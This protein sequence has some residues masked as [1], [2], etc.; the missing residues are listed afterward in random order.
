MTTKLRD[1]DAVILRF[2][3]G[4]NSRASEDQINPLECTDGQNFILDPGNSEFRR[5]PPFDFVAAAPN[6]E[7]IRGFATLQDANGTVTMLVQAGDTVYSFNGVSS[8]TSVGSVSATARLRGPREAYWALTDEVIITDLALQED[9]L[10]WDGST[11]ST[12][13]FLQNDGSSSFGTL[14]AKYCL[15]DNERA[16]FANIVE[17]ANDF[18]HLL[19]ASAQGDY[20]IVSASDRPSSSLSAEDP[21]F[22]PAPQLRPINGLAQLYGVLVISQENGAFEKL[23]GSSAMDYAL[24]RLHPGSGATGD[25][26]VVSI[27][28]DIV[29][30][31]SGKIESLIATDRFGDVQV[32][33][34]SFK[35]E[36]SVRA[37]RIWRLY[38]NPRFHRVYCF[39]EQ[40]GEC[41]VLHT[42]FIGSELSAWAVW[43]TTHELD[44]QP[45]AA[46]ICRDPVDGLEYLF[47]GDADGNIYRMEGRGEA[48]DGGT[49]E[50]IAERTSLL[51]AA[52][53]DAK[54]FHLNGWLQHRKRLETAVEMTVRFA[55]EIVHDVTKTI[56]LAEL[57]T[58]NI[59]VYGGDVYYGGDFYYG[60]SQEHRFV[61]RKWGV[62][63][64][65]NLFQIHLSIQ[66]VNDFA[67]SE[68]GVRYD[69]AS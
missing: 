5:R 69:F 23:T 14:K 68:L 55:G 1:E 57:D 9:V 40:V 16:F 26:S 11:L 12:V 25:E 3:G 47:M 48:G 64:Q 60:P 20:T 13:S 2:G 43:T 62:P 8:F 27:T 52:P 7:E 36:P 49:E 50:I 67:L 63:G 33:D 10:V 29:Y 41:W 6:E 53:L 24:E 54:G 56:Q 28:N 21:W 46:M 19:V 34:L 42:D 15:V 51:F 22:L 59:T 35:I 18:P 61:R 38:Y 45:T 37:N 4:I 30:G 58:L 44:F 31:S 17:N 65:S 66:G 39:P 32:D